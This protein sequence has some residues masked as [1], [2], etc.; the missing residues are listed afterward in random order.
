MYRLKTPSEVV[1]KVMLLEAH[2]VET[3]VLESSS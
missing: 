1:E 3:A 2:G